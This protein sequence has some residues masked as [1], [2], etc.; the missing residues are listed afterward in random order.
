MHT[1]PLR[2]NSRDR[3]KAGN[4]ELSLIRVGAFEWLLQVFAGFV[5]RSAGV[6]IRLHRLPIFVYRPVSLP[7]DVKDFPECDV[8][9]DLGPL[10]IIVSPQRIPVGIRW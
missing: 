8:A 6:V 10:G 5:D 1:K 3:S 9:P 4:Q 2:P 7:G